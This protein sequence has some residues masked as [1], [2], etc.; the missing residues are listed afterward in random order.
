MRKLLLLAV[1]AACAPDVTKT[2][3]T[4]FTTAVFDPTTSEI[5][6]PNDLAFTNPLNTI[7]DP[8]DMT[9]SPPKCALTSPPPM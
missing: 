5:P 8:Q 3:P 2:A 6:L 4:E 9:S 1:L 7:C